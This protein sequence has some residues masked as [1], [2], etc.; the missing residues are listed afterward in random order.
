MLHAL[1]C[2]QYAHNF[3]QRY[4]AGQ[5]NG[6]CRHDIFVIMNSRQVQLT[7]PDDFTYLVMIRQINYAVFQI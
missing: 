1:K 4:A 5:R 7:D 6:R 3:F 2:F